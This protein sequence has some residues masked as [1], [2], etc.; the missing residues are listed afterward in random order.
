MNKFFSAIASGLLYLISLLPFFCIYL[1][2][3]L[4]YFILY[5]VVKYRRGVVDQNLLNSFAEKS[6]AERKL[7]AKQYF[8]FLADQILE[9]LKMR[10][11][12]EQ[13]MRR[14]YQFKGL[15]IFQEQFAKGK[16]VLIATGHYGNWEWGTLAM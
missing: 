4:L 9:T 3:D 13:E 15:E 11:I 1:L 14:R 5:Y 16:S 7:I 2:A 10:S 8:H 6:E 12:S